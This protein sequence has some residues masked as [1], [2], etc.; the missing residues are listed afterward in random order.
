MKRFR[1]G[2]CQGASGI[3]DAKDVYFF[4]KTIKFRLNGALKILT[5]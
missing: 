2:T 3:F 5:Q 1:Q 4:C